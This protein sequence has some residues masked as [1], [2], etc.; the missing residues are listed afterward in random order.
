MISQLSRV[1]LPELEP[2]QRRSC[3]VRSTEGIWQLMCKHIR[4][5]ASSRG[6]LR[7]SRSLRSHHLARP[8]A[9][10]QG[11]CHLHVQGSHCIETG[12]YQAAA[13]TFEYSLTMLVSLSTWL[14]RDGD[15]G[16]RCED[17]TD[18]SSLAPQPLMSMCSSIT[19]S[20]PAILLIGTQSHDA[21]GLK[22]R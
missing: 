4:Q 9:P 6:K 7:L 3:N 1:N 22:Y 14:C 17:C 13:V 16:P 11:G 5:Q 20:L 12:I 15:E 21:L 8:M 10:Q 18:V 19:S 2:R